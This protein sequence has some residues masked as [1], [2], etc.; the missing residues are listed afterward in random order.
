[1]NDKNTEIVIEQISLI[2]GSNFVIS[3]QEGIEGDVFNPLRERIRAGKGRIRQLGTDYLAYSLID[4]VVDNYFIIL[5]KLGEKIESREEELV[6]N[7]TPETLQTIHNL[8][9]EM[10]FLRK[11]VWP[12]RELISKLEREESSLIHES[13]GLYLR[14]VYDHTIQVIDTVETYRDMLSGMLDIY[15]SSV[16]NRMNEVMKVLTIIATIF[17][18]LT[19]VAGIYGMNFEFM[20]ELKWH[21]VYPWAFWLVIAG[22]TGFLVFYFKRKKWL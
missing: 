15:L 4:A 1:P 5:E 3:F 17:I 6:T 13:T 9:R 14:D 7:P 20:P 10:I 16:S 8:K 19:F 11:S 2:L 18:P 12:L 21:W 22:I